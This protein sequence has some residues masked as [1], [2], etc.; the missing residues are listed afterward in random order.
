M[1]WPQ[2]TRWPSAQ[3]TK[4]AEASDPKETGHFLQLSSAC[5]FLLNSNEAKGTMPRLILQRLSH[6]KTEGLF[7]A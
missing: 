1:A 7:L 3:A 5:Q 6:V 2:P 4:L